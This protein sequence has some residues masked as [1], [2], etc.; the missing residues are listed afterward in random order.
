MSD[1]NYLFQ[2][3]NHKVLITYLTVGYP[4]IEATL[5]IAP[6]LAKNGCDLIEL[7]IPFSDPLA[8]GATIQ[9]ASFYALQNKVTP[10]LCLSTAEQLHRIV[11]IP[12]VFMSYFN[13]LFNYGL[14]AFCSDCVAVGIN[15]LIIPDLPPEEGSVLEL[16]TQKHNLDLIYL[17]APNSTKTRIEL[18]TEKSKGF[19]YL[20]SLTGVT[21]VRDQLTHG[22]TSFVG[23]VRNMSNKPICIGF[24]ISTVEQAQQAALMADGIIIGSRIIDLMG[25]IDNRQAVVNF[26]RNVRQSLDQIQDRS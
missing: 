9:R 24:G 22:L 14:E 20:V 25:S 1:L 6:L 3:P 10:R 18:V 4:N 13:P 7:G 5:E 19:I 17:L 23:R 11:K 2:K 8:D 21:G 15:G 26:I 16:I 12:L